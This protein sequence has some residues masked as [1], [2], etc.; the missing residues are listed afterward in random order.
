VSDRSKHLSNQADFQGSQLSSNNLPRARAGTVLAGFFV[1]LP[2]FL[3]YAILFRNALNL[4]ILDDYDA[5][6]NFLN[7]ITQLNTT[8]A[9][10]A[11]F[12]ASQHNEYKLFLT[13]GIVWLAYSLG[14]HIDF[15]ILFA[16]GNGFVLLLAILLWKMFLPNSRDTATRLAYFIPVTCLLFQLQYWETLNWAMTGIQN[17]GVLVFSLGTIYLLLRGQRSAFYCAL[18]SLVLAV[19]SSGNGIIVIPIGVMI[20]AFER[21]YLRIASW[22]VVSAGCIA[23]YAYHYSTVTSAHSG[24]HRSVFLTILHMNPAY[25]IA[26]IGSAGSVPFK[27]GS[28]VLGVLLCVF[29]AW[30]VRRGYIRKNP[31]VSYCVLFLL[32]T[33]IGVAGIRSDFGIEKATTARYTI[34]STLLLIFAWFGIVEEFLQHRPASLFHNDVFLCAVVVAVLFSLWGDLGGWLQIEL[35]NRYV[36]QAMAVFENPALPNSSEGPSPPILYSPVRAASDAFNQRARA[37]LTQ[38]IK[39]GIYQPQPYWGVNL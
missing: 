19:S 20:L 31:F 15:R 4:P 14:G 21:R 36:V 27:L 10:A 9:K 1:A 24:A 18:A 2:A 33:A 28:F 26:F 16:I 25:A 38:S 5:L 6:L 8:S 13:H 7:Q 35:R 34:Y 23:A 30:M 32:L 29:F 12:L 39:L 17:L 22:V 37:I 11:Y 3:F